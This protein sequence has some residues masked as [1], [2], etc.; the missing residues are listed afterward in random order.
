MAETDTNYEDPRRWKALALLSVAYLMVVLDISIVNVALPSIQSELD[1]A[2]ENLQWV[3][4]GYALTFGGFLLLGG[5]LGDLLGRRRLFMVG[6]A[7]FAAHLAPRRPFGQ[8][9]DADRHAAA[10]GRR[11][12]DPLAVRLLDH[13]GHLP[14]GPGAQQGARHPGRHRGRRRG[15]RRLA[16][17][18]PHRLRRLGVDLLRQRPDRRSPRSTSSPARAARAA[19]PTSRDTSTPPA[20]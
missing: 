16:R 11:R 10:P 9:G 3:V 18:D 2:P 14:G 1:F 13:L 20:P 12:R 8:L 19:P 15:D 5:R 7:L 17:R 4:S 6:L